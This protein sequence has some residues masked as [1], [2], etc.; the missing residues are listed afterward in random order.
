MT[1]IFESS[2]LRFSRAN[3][4]ILIFE[5]RQR[6]FL[7]AKEWSDIIERDTDGANYLHK[8]RFIKPFPGDD[9]AI[10]ASEAI[11]HLRATLDHA[12]YAVAVASGKINPKHAYFPFASDETELPKVITGRCKDIPTNITTLFAS[13][14]PYKGG[15]DLLYAL[16]SVCIANKHRKLTQMDIIPDII[17]NRLRATSIRGPVNVTVPQVVWDRGKNE[18]TWLIVPANPTPL[19]DRNVIITLNIAFDNIIGGKTALAVLNDMASIVERILLATEAEA[20]RIGL[21]T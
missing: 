3:E 10:I 17:I 13:F 20:R 16:N 11:E 8:A 4:H 6:A 15:D 12:A 2:K 21:I 14:Q 18:I 7:K 9:F 5:E 19:I 1:D